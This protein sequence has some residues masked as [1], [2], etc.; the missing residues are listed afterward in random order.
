MWKEMSERMRVCEEVRAKKVS[1]PERSDFSCSGSM[2]TH[3]HTHTNVS[4]TA[5]RHQCVCV[6]VCASVCLCHVTV[7]LCGL[8]AAGV[9]RA[10]GWRTEWEGGHHVDRYVSCASLF[11]VSSPFSVTAASFHLSPLHY[12]SSV[13]AS[14]LLPHLNSN[15]LITHSLSF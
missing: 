12:H 2:N 11:S 6:C 5:S 13:G 10:L 15:F 8:R 7:E 14:H 4:H 9:I 3:T 1:K